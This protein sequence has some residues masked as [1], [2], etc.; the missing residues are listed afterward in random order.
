MNKLQR[1]VKEPA[2]AL[3]YLKRKLLPTFRKTFDSAEN[4]RSESDDGRYGAAI[5]KALSSQS[6]FDRFKRDPNYNAILEHVTRE[7]A[8]TY[9]DILQ[10]RDD[11]FLALGLDTVLISDSIGSPR[12]YN[13]SGF[14]IPLSSTTLRYIKVASDLNLLFGSK[15]ITVAE[16]GCGYG[17]QCLV[18]DQLLSVGKATLFDLPIATQL[19]TRY[20][21]NFLLNGAYEICTINR[22]MPESYDLVISNYAF[23]E[24]PKNLQLKYIEKVLSKSK[25]G[26]LTMNSGR[27]GGLDRSFPKLSIKELE[28]RL[29]KFDVFEEKPLTFEYNYIISWGHNDGV[30]L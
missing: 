3:S 18:N 7:Q 4:N 22:A 14:D 1:A 10:S 6:A 5:T 13:F 20:L 29:P 28:E 9:I 8:D 15:F 23:S 17:G 26:Y 21:E 16:I 27:G 25:R 12:R 24:L 2:L 19:I 30:K 11:G